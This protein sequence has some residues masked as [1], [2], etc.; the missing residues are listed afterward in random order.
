MRAL[1]LLAAL[2]AAG[3]SNDKA[4]AAV[5]R[6]VQKTGSFIWVT[7][8]SGLS[9]NRRRH[10]LRAQRSSVFRTGQKQIDRRPRSV[11]YNLPD[12]DCSAGES[13]GELS[14]KEFATVLSIA[15]AANTGQ[16]RATPQSQA[17]TPHSPTPTP[18]LRTP[19][20]PTP[21]GPPCASYDG[22][23]PLRPAPSPPYLTQ[24][25]L[26]AHFIVD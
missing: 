13:A 16:H 5:V 24:L 14:A 9:E 2:S 12:R 26:P 15:N 1:T 23:V 3:A 17:K 25:G 6:M 7:S 21:N 20:T 19:A 4:N 22:R 18:A 10:P 8:R 11:L